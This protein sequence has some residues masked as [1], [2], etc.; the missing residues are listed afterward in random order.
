MRSVATR[1]RTRGFTLIELLVVIAIIAVLI[2]LLLPA[3]QKVREA[4]ARMSCSNNLKQISLAAHNYASANDSRFPNGTVADPT[5]NNYNFISCLAQLLPYVEQDNAYKL[6]PPEALQDKPSQPRTA[7]GTGWSLI[8]WGS[9]S[10][11]GGG[12][13]AT[14]GPI[15]TAARTKVKAYDCPSDGDKYSQAVGVFIGLYISSNTLFGTYNANGGNAS[16]AGR[17]NYVGNCGQFGPAYSYKGVFYAGSKTRIMEISDGTSNTVCFGETLGGEETG[18]RNYA[19]SWMGAG[20]LPF[21]WGLPTPATWNTYGSK[22]SGVI[23]FGFCDGSV[24]P[25]KKG[26]ATTAGS[27]DWYVLMR[28]VG[29]NDGEIVDFNLLGQ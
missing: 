10:V 8:W 24:R 15:V 28:A 17:S 4:A 26:F 5:Q 9:V 6:I 29:I 14:A 23:M 7:A 25:M 2:G 22:H 21:Y 27:S 3:V 19:L 1:N 12:T 20:S 11:G 13:A 16:D 18:T